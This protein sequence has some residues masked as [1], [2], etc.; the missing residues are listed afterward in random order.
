MNAIPLR[1]GSAS[2]VVGAVAAAVDITPPQEAE[3]AL[4]ALNEGLEQR[5]ADE[6]ERCLQAEAELR[7][8]QKMEAIERIERRFSPAS[9]EPCPTRCNRRCAA[10]G[11]RRP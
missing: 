3:R 8:A 10:S 1:D 9:D 11:G 7:Q 2:R 5:V 4:R 6:I